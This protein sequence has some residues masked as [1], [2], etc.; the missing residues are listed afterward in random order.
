M[1]A[2]FVTILWHIG[3][4]VTIL[5]HVGMFVTILWHIGMFVTILWHVGTFVTILRHVGAFVTILWHIG[6]F[7]TILRHIGT[8]VTILRHIGTFVTDYNQTG[9]LALQYLIDK[10]YI[11]LL[12]PSSNIDDDVDVALKK[13]AYPPYL[14]DVLATVL[15]ANLPLFIVLSFL[16]NTIQMAKN[17]AYEKELKLKVG[18]FWVDLVRECVSMC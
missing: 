3:P 6:T 5:R 10:A 2:M 9:F 16:L 13:M 18:T 1:L 15:Q 8:F 12:N 17:L 14:D 4:F 11:K 7:V